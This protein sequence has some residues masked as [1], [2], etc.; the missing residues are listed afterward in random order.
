MNTHNQACSH[1]NRSAA[2]LRGQRS[3]SIRA[4]HRQTIAALVAQGKRDLLTTTGLLPVSAIKD[5][6]FDLH[7]GTDRGMDAAEIRASVFCR[8][9]QRQ[10]H[11]VREQAQEFQPS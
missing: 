11:W 1:G 6:I 3:T 2:I 5:A 10:R 7:D 9:A 4:G 8:F